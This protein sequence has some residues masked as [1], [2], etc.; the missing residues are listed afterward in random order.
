MKKFFLIIAAIILFSPTTANSADYS[1]NSAGYIFLQVEKNGEAWYVYPATLRRY[2][3]GRPADAFAIMGKLSLGAKHDFISRTEIFPA[4]LSGLILLDVES[5]GEAYYIYPKD[6]KKY[7]LGRPDDALRI[8][9]ELGQGISNSGLEKI[10]IGNM[11]YDEADLPQSAKILQNVPFV[12]QAPFD[13]WSDPRQNDGCEEASSLMAVRW[14][15]GQILKSEEALG[16][17]IASSDF[18][19]GKYGEY[20]DTSLEDTLNWI[21]KDYFKYRN[22]ALKKISAASDL[23]DELSK[24]NIIIAP[25]NGQAL[26]NPYYRNPGP[27]H[28][29]IVIIGYDPAKDVFI[30]NDPG[31]EMG[32]AHE[33]AA[34]LLFGAIRDYPTGFHES[35]SVVEKNIIVVWK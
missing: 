33:Y 21:V 1:G 28:H 8:M 24:E 5:H 11:N 16:E 22:A 14:A 25:M 18:I 2:Y 20:R 23:I 7:Y 19:L 34:N 31:T 30:T 3:L 35:I 17:I 10:P 15:R 4:Q 6:R 9:S 13:E 32:R 29:M 26:G 27:I 12:P